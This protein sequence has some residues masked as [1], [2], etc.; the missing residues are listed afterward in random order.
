MLRQACGSWSPA[1]SPAEGG[2]QARP[3]AHCT[4]QEGERGSKV[5]GGSSRV[6]SLV[7]SPRRAPRP[8]EEIQ[9]PHS[10]LAD[11]MGT[12]ENIS[13][14]IRLH[15]D[16]CDLGQVLTSRGRGGKCHPLDGG[17]VPGRAKRHAGGALTAVAN[18]S[19]LLVLSMDQPAWAW[20]SGPS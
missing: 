4:R 14:Q 9:G 13:L 2:T 12:R 3:G 15:P 10:S 7:D 20:S 19:G 17:A 8:G 5:C 1:A 11:S 18:S 6:E 16:C